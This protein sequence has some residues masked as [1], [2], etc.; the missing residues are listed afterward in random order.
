MDI[1]ERHFGRITTGASESGQLIVDVD[2]FIRRLL[3]FEHC[4]TET[5]MLKE[6]PS[7]ISVFGAKG[8]LA[9]LESGA[10]RVVCDAMTAGQ[11]GQTEGL[12][13]TIRRGGSLS[14]GDRE[15]LRLNSSHPQ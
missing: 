4:I 3:L 14:P 9:L 7:L 2:V 1:R 10:I 11:A 12:K 15:R 6:I 13:S 5:D 8:F